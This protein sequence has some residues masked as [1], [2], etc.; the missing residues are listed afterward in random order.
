MCCAWWRL[1]VRWSLVVVCGSMIVVVVCSSLL[2]FVV[3]WRCWSFVVFCVLVSSLL[4][5]VVVC[6]GC[7]LL[8]GA[9]WF[10]VCVCCCCC[11]CVVNAGVVCGSLVHAGASCSSLRAVV[12]CWLAFGVRRFVGVLFIVAD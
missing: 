10:V 11:H 2:L 12:R 6:V 3:R 1:F 4:F 7:M 5:V 9:V 8:D